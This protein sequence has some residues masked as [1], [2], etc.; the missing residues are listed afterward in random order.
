ML[1]EQKREQYINIEQVF[2]GKS[3]KASCTILLVMREEAVVTT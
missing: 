1:I 3:A 2:H